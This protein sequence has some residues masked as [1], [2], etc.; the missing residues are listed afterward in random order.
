MKT[1]RKALVTMRY[2]AM[3][4]R[5]EIWSCI[6]I[7]LVRLLALQG[8]CALPVPNHLDQLKLLTEA[9]VPDLIVL[10]GG[11]SLAKYHGPQHSE[12]DLIEYQLIN[13]AF[14]HN[15]PLIGICR[16]MQVIL[17]FFGEELVPVP[18]HVKTEHSLKGKGIQM[19]V[20]SFHHYGVERLTHP[21]LKIT[22]RAEDGVIEAISHRCRPVHGIMWHPERSH[23]T[24]PYFTQL[25]RQT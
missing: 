25:I 17:D 20:N 22:Y 7:A 11:E 2:Q 3:P 13:Y 6:D 1:P 23:M 9:V 19:K 15:I 10:S 12:R 24:D 4:D 14:Q 21:D 18:G 16:G 8:Y 5:N